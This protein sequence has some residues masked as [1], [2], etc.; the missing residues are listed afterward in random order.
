MLSTL[1][2]YHITGNTLRLSL[3]YQDLSGLTHTGELRAQDSSVTEYSGPSSYIPKT[4][5]RTSQVPSQ[6]DHQSTVSVV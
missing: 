3:S 1:I 4:H 2:C 6:T 5:Q